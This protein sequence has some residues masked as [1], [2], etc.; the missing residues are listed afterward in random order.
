[1]GAMEEVLSRA[2]SGLVRE[3]DQ[4]LRVFEEHP[5]GKA[6]ELTVAPRSTVEKFP[7]STGDILILQSSDA[8]AMTQHTEVETFLHHLATR[9]MVKFVFHRLQ[10]GS[11]TFMNGTTVTPAQPTKTE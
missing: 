2:V 10:G 1:M 9:V 5:Q 6:V 3:E 4:P 8:M 7:L 11:V